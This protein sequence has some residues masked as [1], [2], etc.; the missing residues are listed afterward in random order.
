MALFTDGTISTIDDLAGHDAGLLDVAS[1]VGIDVSRKLKLAQDD[2]ELEL[3]GL[4]P[5]GDSVNNV[6]VTTA[7]RLWHAFH[8]LELVY[9][10]AFNDQLND[11][12]AGK[13]DQFAGLAKWAAD[14]LIARGVA[15][16][17]K[18]V[19]KAGTALLS[20]YPGGQA[21]ATY[22][23]CTSW[24][25]ADGGEG[26]AGEWSAITV[27]DGNTLCVQP[28]DPPENATGWNVFTGLSPETISRQNGD[29]I[30]VTQPWVQQGAVTTTGAKP[31]SGQTADAIRLV[32]RVLLRG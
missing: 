24:V 12:Y 17:G 1:T 30:D 20:Y 18:P 11:R 14:K 4:L 31:G 15:M 21:G 16:I 25:N 26:A 29:V 10:D 23:V 7:L 28:A 2:L 13:R 19:P 9:R 5:A 3:T 27:P 32:A 8:A 22:Y 6:A